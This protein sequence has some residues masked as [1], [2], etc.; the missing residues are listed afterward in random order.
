MTD[1]SVVLA[2]TLP[3]G[4]KFLGYTTTQ[5]TCAPPGKGSAVV[6]C[7]VGQI[8]P[9]ASREA[10]I[11]IRVASSTTGQLINVARV[12]G[13]RFDPVGSNNLATVKTLAQ[14]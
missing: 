12:S 14:K 3:A 4:T 2:N 7:S 13:A 10:K 8:E 11:T 5:G 6:K 1:P 9:G